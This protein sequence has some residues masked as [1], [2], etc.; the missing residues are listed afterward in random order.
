MLKTNKTIVAMDHYA[1]YNLLDICE[2]ANLSPFFA[3]CSR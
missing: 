1:L 2:Y 3:H